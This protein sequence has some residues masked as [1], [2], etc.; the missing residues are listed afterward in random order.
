M[1]EHIPLV[2]IGFKTVMLVVGGLI[3]YL[4]AKAAQR[5][6]ID[7]LST[8]AVGFGI[9]TFGSLLAGV[10]D[11][12]LQVDAT[13]ALVVQNALTA[14]GFCLVAYSLYLTKDH[15]FSA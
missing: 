15:S 5:T 14:V 10:A 7:G 11:Q 2:V 4:A 13:T 1:T 9:I 8:L 12:L 6:G 3:T